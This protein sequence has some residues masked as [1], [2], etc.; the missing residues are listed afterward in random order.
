[1]TPARLKMLRIAAADPLGVV[2]M[3]VGRPGFSQWKWTRMMQSMSNDGFVTPYVH[4][5]Y[6]I[7]SAGRLVVANST[8]TVS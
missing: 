4:G 2:T 3:P 8:E 6:E 5:G 1:M 7:T